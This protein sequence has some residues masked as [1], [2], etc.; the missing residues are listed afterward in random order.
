MAFTAFAC[1]GSGCNSEDIPGQ[2]GCHNNQCLSWMEELQKSEATWE[3][4][5]PPSYNYRI[6]SSAAHQSG[7][8]MFYSVYDGAVTQRI[9]STWQ[10]EPKKLQTNWQE[11]ENELG[12]HNET[13][14]IDKHSYGV[15]TMEGV[16]DFC[17]TKVLV[18]DLD[19]YEV[20]LDF[21]EDGYLKTCDH[22]ARHCGEACS[23]GISIE[24][25]SEIVVFSD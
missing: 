16:Y 18:K 22:K 2:D 14:G 13:F 1:L 10:G 7:T 24:S 15:W 12:S 9:F 11:T 23:A 17:R 20:T 8:S 25:L 3:E 21:D 19:D 4:T 6:E 5:A